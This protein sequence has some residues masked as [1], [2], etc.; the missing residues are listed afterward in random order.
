MGG[1]LG[2]VGVWGQRFSPDS[3]LAHFPPD[4]GF[5]RVAVEM[6]WVGLILFCTLLFV[7]LKTGINNYFLIQNRELKAYCLAMTIM[8]FAIAIGNYPQEALV[9]YPTT[10]YFYLMVAILNKCLEL[11]KQLQAEEALK[12]PAQL[13]V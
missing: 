4:S 5:V 1:G 9:Q 13:L 7:I 3:M 10:V 8:I 6:G 12:Q 11:D 2:S